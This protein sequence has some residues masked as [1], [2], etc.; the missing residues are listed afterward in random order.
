MVGFLRGIDFVVWMGR[1]AASGTSA[2]LCGGQGQRLGA[3]LCSERED[4][5]PVGDKT[6]RIQL[7]PAAW[8]G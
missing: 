1:E 6:G 5:G 8:L 4:E 7:L 2:G 3:S